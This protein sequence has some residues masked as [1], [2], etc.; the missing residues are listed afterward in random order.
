[1]SHV[2]NGVSFPSLRSSPRACYRKPESVAQLPVESLAHLRVEWVVYFTVESL[3]H[4]RLEYAG[5][6][7]ATPIPAKEA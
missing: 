5:V 4:F 7:I 6:A 1:M 2:E 3:A